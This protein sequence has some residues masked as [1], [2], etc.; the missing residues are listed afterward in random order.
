MSKKS[1]STKA[2]EEADR[3]SRKEVLLARKQAQ[4]TRQLRIAL[5]I[6]GILILAVIVIAVVNEFV[7]APNR[8]VAVVNDNEISL[9]DFQDRV[10]YERARRVVLLEDQLAA[11]GG[12]VG[13][14]QQFA[15]QVLVDL[16]PANAETFG[17]TV[18]NQMVDEDLI[19]QAAGDRGITVSDADVEAEIGKSFNYYGGELPTPLPTATE[20]VMPTPSL[21]PIPT[22]VI[23]EVVPTATSFPTPT[24]GPTN[25]PLPTSTPVSADSF[26][27]QLDELLQQYRDLGVSEGAYRAS[28]RAQLYR[29]RLADALAEEENLSREAEHVNFYVLVFDNQEEAD[30]VAGTLTSDNYLEVW[31]TIRSQQADPNAASTAFASELFRR[32]EDDLATSFSPEFATAV[33]DQE[34]DTPT[35]VIAVTGQDGTI[36]YFIAIPSG[37]EMLPLTDAAYQTK[38]DELVSALITSL[39]GGNVIVQDF[40]RDRVPTKPALDDK[41]YATPTPV[42][43]QPIVP[44]VATPASTVTAP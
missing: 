2:K 33:F 3:Q 25:T 6:V 17:E 7:V 12:D 26:Q 37:K 20:T 24:A 30:N 21:T 36:S 38:K 4:Q 27:Q 42:P 29:Q 16:Y 10:V 5:G 28:V 23:T 18:L 44:E 9:Q 40:W 34:I 43:E 31:N 15:N 39:R 19:A 11:F 1:T 35:P 22:A 8:S 32:T 14:I 41:F 13:I